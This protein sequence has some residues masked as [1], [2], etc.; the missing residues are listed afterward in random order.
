MLEFINKCIDSLSNTT[1][2][3]TYD[4]L[5]PD[6]VAEHSFLVAHIAY[7]IAIHE[8]G[9]DENEVVKRA[10]FHDIEES[11]TGDL[12]RF[13]KRE[14]EDFGEILEEV[15]KEGV[16]Q[17]LKNS[18]L[19]KEEKQEVK[20]IWENA[21]DESKEGKIIKQADILA[22]VYDMYREI[23]KGNEKIKDYDDVPR[24]INDAIS[25][26]EGTPVAEDML[27]SMLDE[28]NWKDNEF[29]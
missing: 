12:P 10:L 28:I 16:N 21:K 1:R 11:Y 27:Y 23:L 14:N 15:E 17:I 20:R 3:E 19:D 18:H 2:W 9:C 24:G 22:A 26:C 13:S 7:Q 29:K 4:V 25:I 6:S 5:D 8:E